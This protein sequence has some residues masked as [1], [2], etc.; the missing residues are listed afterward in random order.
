[1]TEART[2]FENE[3][4]LAQEHEEV[5]PRKVKTLDANRLANTDLE[6]GV[7][8]SPIANIERT[9]DNQCE[10]VATISPH[11]EEV[12]T[13][14]LERP[15]NPAATLRRERNRSP[16]RCH[17]R[18]LLKYLPTRKL[19]RDLLVRAFNVVVAMVLDAVQPPEGGFRD[20]DFHWV[21]ECLWDE[22]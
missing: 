8:M 2:N 21:Q 18:R 7:V 4:G 17:L 14:P 6:L 9:G 19:A 22:L 3:V 16:H 15:P 1:M 11:E 20:Q 10:A 5:V 13:P 12:P